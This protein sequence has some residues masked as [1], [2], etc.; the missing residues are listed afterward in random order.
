MQIPEIFCVSHLK[1]KEKTQP[2][3]SNGQPVSIVFWLE[4]AIIHDVENSVASYN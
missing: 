3:L 2:L 1:Q 4:F